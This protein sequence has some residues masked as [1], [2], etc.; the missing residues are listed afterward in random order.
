MTAGGVRLNRD[1]P[2]FMTSDNDNI[3]SSYN[4]VGLKRAGFDAAV[5]EDI[6]KAYNII[7]RSELNLSNALAELEKMSH[8]EEVR[9]LIEFI[10]TSKRGICLSRSNRVL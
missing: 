8:A 6:K 7:Y 4:I 5:R 9:H 1:L 2:P 10:R 3:V